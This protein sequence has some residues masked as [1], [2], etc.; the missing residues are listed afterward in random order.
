MLSICKLTEIFQFIKTKSPQIIK[1][2]VE[3][4][5]AWDLRFIEA[6]KKQKK[7]ME[8]VFMASSNN[9]HSSTRETQI[10]TLLIVGTNWTPKM[11]NRNSQ[12]IES[13]KMN[14]LN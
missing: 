1:I 5:T 9:R 6:S 11:M 2:S 4:Y 8:H 10:S 14:N 7:K 3:N 12:H 13:I